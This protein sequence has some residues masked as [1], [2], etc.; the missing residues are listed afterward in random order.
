M[1][2]KKVASCIEETHPNFWIWKYT[3]NFTITQ[4]EKL[5]L[6][7]LKSETRRNIQRKRKPTPSWICSRPLTYG[8]SVF[9][10]VFCGKHIYLN[11]EISG[12]LEESKSNW[13]STPLSPIWYL[14]LWSVK[15][16][17]SQG[18]VKEAKT[19]WIVRKKNTFRLLNLLNLKLKIMQRKYINSNA[20]IICIVGRWTQWCTMDYHTTLQISM[21]TCIWTSSLVKW[22]K[23]LQW[24]QPWSS[25]TSIAIFVTAT[26]L[27]IYFMQCR[28]NV[29][30][31]YS[32]KDFLK[33]FVT[34][35]IRFLNVASR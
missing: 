18:S 6:C 26:V 20:D 31:A 5:S 27:N 19:M 30:L 8:K 11:T 15:N 28:H 7:L 16:I 13:K 25:S 22:W 10:S 1:L 12:C 2:Q 34:P 21:A 4:T 32:Y 33:D 24:W 9:V 29:W 3:H 35:S 23:F 14:F 17:R